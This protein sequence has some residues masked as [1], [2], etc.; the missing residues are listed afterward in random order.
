MAQE[1]VLAASAS[2]STTASTTGTAVQLPG[3]W[4][5]LAVVLDV[6]SS[7]VDVGDT[8]DVYVDLSFDNV[9]W[10][11]VVH[12]AQQAGTGAAKTE[13]AILDPSNPGT[14]TF[15]V[16]ADCAAGVTRPS[17]F[18]KWVRARH[19]I[20]NGAGGGTPEHVFSVKAYS[21]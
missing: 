10:F 18:G 7:G 8:L 15:V 21:Q 5:R 4:K 11:N 14:A 9:K 16:T 17:S 2:R 3:F 13:I 12:F 1:L 20:V 19:V 6:T